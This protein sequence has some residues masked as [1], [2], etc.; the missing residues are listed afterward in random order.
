M[1]LEAIA[2]ATQ[3]DG[4]VTVTLNGKQVTRDMHVFGANPKWAC[5]LHTCG[6]DSVVKVGKNAKTGDHG[7]TMMFIGYPTDR[8]SD[9]VRMWDPTMNRVVVTR[10]VIWLQHMHFDRPVNDGIDDYDFSAGDDAVE[11]VSEL[12]ETEPVAEEAVD[13]AASALRDNT[14]VQGQPVT[15]QSLSVNAKRVAELRDKEVH[16]AHPVATEA[17]VNTKIGRTV[18]RSGHV[19]KPRKRLIES[20]EATAVDIMY[21][22]SMAELDNLEVSMIELMVVNFEL[23]LVGAGIDGGFTNNKHKQT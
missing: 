17:L 14:Y 18:T 9:S 10:D 8:E 5:N 7:I 1:A 20:L 4:L 15:D 19:V 11:D 22:G 16:W 13:K 2:C 6:E 12:E 21:L 23:N 3:L